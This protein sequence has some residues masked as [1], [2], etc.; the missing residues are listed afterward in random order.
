MSL[1]DTVR[2]PCAVG[3]FPDLPVRHLPLTSP[4]AKYL[5]GLRS[6]PDNRGEVEPPTHV[7]SNG[8]HAICWPWQLKL[9]VDARA[10]D[11]LGLPSPL[12]RY[13]H[14]VSFGY[15]SRTVQ[16]GFVFEGSA[17]PRLPRP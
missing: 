4:A 15:R 3:S 5:S 8:T 6:Y 17:L 1:T 16:V 12:S 10:A 2:C 13:R 9:K 7:L 14:V 11:T